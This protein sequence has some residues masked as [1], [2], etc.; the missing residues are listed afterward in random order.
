MKRIK[1]HVAD[2][3]SLIFDG[4]KSLL[5]NSNIDIVGYS[6]NGLELL[7]WCKLNNCDVIVLDLSMDVMNG[8]EVLKYFKQHAI[9]KKIVVFSSY[10]DIL[11]I[12]ETIKMGAKSYLLKDDNPDNLVKAI[13]NAHLGKTFY[14]TKVKKYLVEEHVTSK[15]VKGN[16]KILKELLSEKELKIIKLLVN[17]HNTV[18]IGEEMNITPST[19]RS[20]TSKLRERFKTST[21]VGLALRFAFLHD[22]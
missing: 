9:S 22:D 1:V 14:S 20:V 7:E 3:H 12:E 8:I 18:Q 15:G 16:L 19:V 11:F 17:D 5:K 4:I 13:N 2:N 6:K 10:L 21:T